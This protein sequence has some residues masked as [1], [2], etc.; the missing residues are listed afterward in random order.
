M[1]THNIVADI[2]RNVLKAQAGSQDLF[3]SVIC[4]LSVVELMSVIEQVQARSV[5]PAIERFH[6]L[7]LHLA[8]PVNHHLPRRASSSGVTT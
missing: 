1:N 8:Y 6:V 4:T 7:H 3:V 2:H 5:I